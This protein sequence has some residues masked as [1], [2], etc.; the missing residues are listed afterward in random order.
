[1][2]KPGQQVQAAHGWHPGLAQ[3]PHFFG[4]K[5]QEKNRENSCL[6]ATNL[7]DP[8]QGT[9]CVQCDVLAPSPRCA[10][11]GWVPTVP[12]LPLAPPLPGG[13]WRL[14]SHLDS[15]GWSFLKTR[16]FNTDP[17]MEP[18]GWLP[19]LSSPGRW[20]GTVPGEDGYRERVLGPLH[21]GSPVLLR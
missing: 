10:G 8:I 19:S 5:Q 13:C 16:V 18:P 4:A 20:V 15:T 2:L 6:Q 1:M 12:G 11:E 7:G 3:K 21:P 17:T 14:N 9:I